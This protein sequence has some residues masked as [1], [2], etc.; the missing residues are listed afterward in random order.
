[1]RGAVGAVMG[2]GCIGSVHL[3]GAVR[4]EGIAASCDRH[5]PMSR[6]ISLYPEVWGGAEGPR[7]G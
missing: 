3:R 5:E 2:R 6:W 4:A 1:M 7:I